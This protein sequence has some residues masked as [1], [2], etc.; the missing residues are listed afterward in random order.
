MKCPRCEGAG[1]LWPWECDDHITDN[2]YIC[3]A[4]SGTGNVPEDY[5]EE[6]E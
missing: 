2:H 5:K 4:C 1:W 6:E 3:P